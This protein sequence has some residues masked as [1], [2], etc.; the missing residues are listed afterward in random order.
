MSTVHVDLRLEINTRAFLWLLRLTK[1]H[2]CRNVNKYLETVILRHLEQQSEV[3]LRQSP[4][5]EPKGVSNVK[6]A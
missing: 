5:S 3:D 2:H 4:C 6:E 1:E